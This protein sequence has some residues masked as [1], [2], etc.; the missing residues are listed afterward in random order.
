MNVHI[1][2][3]LLCAFLIPALETEKERSWINALENRK[4]EQCA[5]V[6]TVQSTPFKRLSVKHCKCEM[7]L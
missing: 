5:Y 1:I 4:G 6:C 7:L 2:N 3:V